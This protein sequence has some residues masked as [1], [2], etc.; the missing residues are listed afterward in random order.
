V[1]DYI[2][3]LWCT[4]HSWIALS[5]SLQR[6]NFNQHKLV[7]CS[8]LFPLSFIKSYFEFFF[9]HVQFIKKQT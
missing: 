3:T 8:L 4:A 6:T 2:M 7:R 1:Q 5:N 9:M